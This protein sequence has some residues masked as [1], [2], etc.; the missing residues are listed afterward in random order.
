[1]YKNYVPNNPVDIIFGQGKRILLKELLQSKKYKVFCSKRVEK[2]IAR[3]IDKF[4]KKETKCI[5][6]YPE[7]G[8]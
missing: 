6:K 1:M 7:I 2:N 8:F 4:I 3:D 5:N